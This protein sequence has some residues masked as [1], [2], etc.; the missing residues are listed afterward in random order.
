MALPVAAYG[1][2]LATMVTAAAAVDADRGRGR[3][4]A[5]SVLFL[6]SDT[7]IGVRM[8]LLGNP[9]ETLEGAVMA[10]YSLGQWCIAEGL[11]AA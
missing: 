6:L 3:V 1:V 2:T 4:L 11:A 8:F 7:L 9:P 5:G 10:T